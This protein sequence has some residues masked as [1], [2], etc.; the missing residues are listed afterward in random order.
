MTEREVSDERLAELEKTTPFIEEDYDD[1]YS[2][3]LEL[4]EFRSQRR[5]QMQEG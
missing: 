5:R 4:K 3:L 2:C 1:I